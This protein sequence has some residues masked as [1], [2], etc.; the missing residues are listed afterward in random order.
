MDLTTTKYV[1]AF[2]AQHTSMM[3]ILRF[4]DQMASLAMVASA[5][6]KM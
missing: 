6:L 3:S 1:K 5:F 4:L 2:L